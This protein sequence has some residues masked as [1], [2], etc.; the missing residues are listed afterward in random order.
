[1]S[2]RID[3]VFAKL[4]DQGRTAVIPYIACGDPFADATV[5]NLCAA[6][7]V[8]LTPEQMSRLSAA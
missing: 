5:D 4:R 2:S 3:T 8:T 1:M 7:D 6:T